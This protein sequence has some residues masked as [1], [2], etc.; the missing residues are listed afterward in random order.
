MEFAPFGRVVEGMD[1]LAKIHTGYGEGEPKGKGPD[2]RKI[3]RDGN[4]YLRK[5]YPELDWI[6]HATLVQ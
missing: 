5:G 3:E 2:Q 6:E 1:V 4:E